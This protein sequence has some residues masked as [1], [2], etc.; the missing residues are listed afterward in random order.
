MQFGVVPHVSAPYATWD[1][2]LTIAKEA[3]R[4]G[5]DSVW[6][7]D[8]FISPSGRPY[9]LEAWTV[10]SALASSTRKLGWEHM[11]CAI[12]FVTHHSWPRWLRH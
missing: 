7:S 5:Y 9:G 6:V 2:F 11:S 8:H 4:L 3:E 10:L 1:T 12:N